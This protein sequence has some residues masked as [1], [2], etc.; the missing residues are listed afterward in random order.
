[1]RTQRGENTLRNID[2]Q[3]ST[4]L[5]TLGYSPCGELFLANSET[6]GWRKAVC[7]TLSTTIGWQEADTPL[8]AT[9]LSHRV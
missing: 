3:L 7:A 2:P 5:T 6:G 1:M 9:W 8:C 4:T